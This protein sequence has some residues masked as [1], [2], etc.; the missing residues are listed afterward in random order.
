MD[1]DMLYQ[2][3]LTMVPQIGDVHMASLLQHFET[4]E[5]VFSAGR[6]V[7]D[8][9]P[10]IGPVR[11]KSIRS[12]KDFSK[13]EKELDFTRKYGIQ[14]L[15]R[16]HPGY[17]KRLLHCY[18]APSLLYYKGNADINTSRI[19]AIIG[20]RNHTGYGREITGHIIRELAPYEVLIVSG[21]AYGIDAVAHKASLDNRL[22]TIG[23]IAHGLDRIYPPVHAS[24]ARAMIQS[25]GLLTDLRSGTAPD[26][27]NFP[28]RNRI[29]AGIADAVVVIETDIKGGSMITAELANSYNKDVFALPGKV[30]D[31]KSTGCNYL[32]RSNKAALATSGKDILE[33]M[34]WSNPVMPKNIH[35]KKLFIDLTP[36]EKRITEMLSEQTSAHIDEINLHC[37]LSS[38]AIAAAM[39]HLE[40]EGIITALP[41]KHYKLS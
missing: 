8:K 35:Q 14:V 16:N 12:F 26:K 13:A 36:E 11:S 33:Y 34:N 18:D 38:S 22:Q 39:L 40:L 7:L 28:K 9:I 31:A 5:E 20:T 32:I 27:Q 24:L 1:R 2:V 17:P 25:G 10:G 23:V 29:V 41:G 37:R 3:A 15:C 30:T 4:A 21:L 6:R 19:L